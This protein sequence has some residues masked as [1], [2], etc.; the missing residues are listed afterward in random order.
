VRVFFNLA[1]LASLLFLSA[2]NKN[3]PAEMNPDAKQT[4]KNKPAAGISEGQA[5]KPKS[6]TDLD[7]VWRLVE[8]EFGPNVAGEEALKSTT[9]VVIGSKYTISGPHINREGTFEIDRT[10]T[11]HRITI[12]EAEATEVGEQVKY[13]EKIKYHGIVRAEGDKLEIRFVT[14]D[15]MRP[16]DFAVP[17]EGSTYYSARRV[18]E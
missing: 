2:C 12:S 6:A 11:P 15:K 14:L 10:T 5:D 16:I 8:V 18:Q 7:G 9:F 4:G 3:E 17:N 1:I 13:G